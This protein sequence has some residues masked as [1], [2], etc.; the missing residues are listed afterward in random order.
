MLETI[1][2]L[3]LEQLVAS[4]EERGLRH[5]H[6]GWFLASAE[7][8]GPNR[9]GPERAAWLDRLDRE[10]E[11][12]RG[13][14]AWRGDAE[15]GLRLAGS[16]LAFW[17][18]H[19]LIGE[20]ID[21]LAAALGRTSEP[22]LGR[23]RALAVSGI[24]ALLAGDLDGSERAC[25]EALARS[26]PGEEWYRAVCLNAFG[27]GLRYRGSYDG[28]RQRYEEAL[29][30]AAQRDLWW[31]A[32]LAH[33]NL[34]MLAVIEGRHAEGVA[35]HERCS[36]IA[37]EG[38]D[39]WMAA[40]SLTNAGRAVR[41]LGDLDRATALQGEALRSFLA[42]ENGWGVAVCLDAFA[43]LAADRGDPVRAARLYGAEEAIRER[44]GI[45]PW[46]TTRSEHEA[47]IQATAAALGEAAWSR[48]RAQGRA[49]TDDEA[50]AEAGLHPSVATG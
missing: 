35:S 30:L 20:G 40:M 39:A 23:S 8:G 42:L 1:R 2:E 47:G 4:G 48:A 38:G 50:I 10:R 37:R 41:E 49:M 7:D 9:R 46:P 43:G 18:D 29:A 21:A 3:A 28:A 6:A 15:T 44:A 34:G 36:A 5:A 12:V 19:G 26:W 31:P 24:L 16:L 14:L 27:T 13:A 32:A 11:N 25:S 17:L 33:G 45:A 22:S